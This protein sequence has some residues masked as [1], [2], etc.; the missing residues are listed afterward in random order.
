MPPKCTTPPEVPT[1]PK[2]PP[3]RKCPPARGRSRSTA[4]PH[5]GFI[6]AELAKRRNAMA[7]YQDLVEHHGYPGSYDAVKRLVGKLRQARSED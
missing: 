4:E 5:R 7:I 2:P 1:D 6:E 3:G